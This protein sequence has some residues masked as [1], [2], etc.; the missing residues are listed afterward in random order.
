MFQNLF[1]IYKAYRDFVISS[2][3]MRTNASLLSWPFA[4]VSTLEKL[5]N[6]S[7]PTIFVSGLHSQPGFKQQEKKYIFYHNDRT[8]TID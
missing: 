6:I 7:S 5:E 4:K 2:I 3:I 1:K 8:A